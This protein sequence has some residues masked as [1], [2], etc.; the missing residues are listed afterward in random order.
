MA[1]DP[2][3]DAV[4]QLNALGQLAAGVGHHVI[5]AFSA[6][7]SNAEIL[8]LI[9]TSPKP[10][11]PAAI[12]EI[13]IRT[14]V[15]ASGVARRLIDYSRTATAIGEAQVELEKLV[16]GVVEFERLRSPSGID[17]SVEASPVPLVPGN[18]V[19]LAAMLGHVLANARE[20]LPSSG[21]SI[22]VVT[23]RDE[24]GWGFVEVRDTGRGMSQQ[25]VERAVEPFFTTK[26]GHLGVGLSIANGIWRR[27]KGTLSI[28]SQ[29]GEGT[30]VRLGI[31]PPRTGPCSLGRDHG[32]SESGVGPRA[33]RT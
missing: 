26:A 13:I 17:W 19:Q 1:N 18:P 2:H 12:A 31:E 9:P 33:E 5:N 24:R 15:E 4:E 10:I 28:R 11:D 27:H 16:P 22:K 29:L 30:R 23:G 3:A 6:V 21:G 8:R 32:T 25:E 14:A 20:A 7:V